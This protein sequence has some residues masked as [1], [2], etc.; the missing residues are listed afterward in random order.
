MDHVIAVAQSSG[1]LDQIL[2]NIQTLHLVREERLLNPNTKMYLMS[3]DCIAWLLS[4]GDHIIDVPEE[5][6]C[7]EECWCALMPVGE[8]CD[9]VTTSGLKWNLGKVL[10][11]ENLM[12][13]YYKLILYISINLSIVQS[14]YG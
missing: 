6:R 3:G 2:G 14:N 10:Y 5:C 11:L 13:A 1:R 9:S 7:N 12:F 4:P 8:A